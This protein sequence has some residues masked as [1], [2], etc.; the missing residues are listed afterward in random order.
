MLRPFGLALLLALAVLFVN[1]ARSASAAAP[2]LLLQELFDLTQVA[3]GVYAAIKKE[4][5]PGLFT[6]NSVVIINQHDVIVVDA[7][8]WPAAARALISEVA[9]LTAQPIRS[10]ILTHAAPDHAQACQVYQENF[11]GVEII[12]HSGTRDF[13]RTELFTFLD[14]QRAS[15]PDRL[16]ALRS[17]LESASAEQESERLRR[18]LVWLQ[19]YSDQLQRLE[20]LL[21]TTTFENTITLYR[22]GREIQ[23]LASPGGHTLGDVVVYLPREKVL[24]AGDLIMSDRTF[25]GRYFPGRY[26]E[27]LR[28]L[29]Q[30]EFDILVPG[31]GPLLRGKDFLNLQTAL[32]E[33]LISQVKAAAAAG[34][35]LQD[36]Q[37]SL[38]L[39][40][41]RA[42]F[43][44]RDPAFG[45]HF[46]REISRAVVT[47][48]REL[49]GKL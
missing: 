29:Q 27:S 8:G 35:S 2:E 26:P 19:S 3:P 16:A 47:A 33:S 46:N 49:A 32:A 24:I 17:E 37:A 36:T 11:P 38:D 34:K 45:P 10:V 22:G 14:R 1:P 20:L 12:A 21:P 18:H 5:V 40:S 39:A 31:H 41:F 23:L 15:L 9:K 30:L 25:P 48:Y 13:I 7:D 44:A 6:A 4:R 43:V 28:Q 42:R